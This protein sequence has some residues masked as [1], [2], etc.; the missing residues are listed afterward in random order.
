MLK[1]EGASKGGEGGATC[2]SHTDPVGSGDLDDELN[3]V[4]HEK[5]AISPHHQGGSLALGRLHHGDN[6]LNEV[7]R[8]VLVLLEHR[9]PLPQAARP[10][11]LVR[12]RLGLHRR[13]LHHGCRAPSTFRRAVGSAEG[14]DEDATAVAEEGGHPLTG[15]PATPLSHTHPPFKGQGEP[16]EDSKNRI[17][18]IL[19]IL[20]RFHLK[21]RRH[22]W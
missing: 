17:C 15:Q 8:I 21:M 19:F 10:G 11:L 12:V 18:R 14:R 7:L 6:A 1:I 2:R 20:T 16:V 3:G 13:Y 5:P 9:H 4:L 22:S